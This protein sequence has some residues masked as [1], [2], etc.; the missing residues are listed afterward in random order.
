M[1]VDVIVTDQ[2]IADLTDEP[3]PA[4]SGM[5]PM[6]ACGLIICPLL[7]RSPH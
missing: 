3:V 5:G 4:L 2:D 6:L 1:T 7:H